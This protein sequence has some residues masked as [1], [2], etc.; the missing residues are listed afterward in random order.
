[1]VAAQQVAGADPPQLAS[2]ERSMASGKL[3]VSVGG[4][5]SSSV[6]WLLYNHAKLIAVNISQKEEQDNDSVKT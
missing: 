2:H 6:G 1:M 3:C 5:F 4:Q